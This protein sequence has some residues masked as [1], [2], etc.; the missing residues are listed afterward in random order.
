MGT[1]VYLVCS[2]IELPDDGLTQRPSL[3]ALLAENVLEDKSS[4]HPLQGVQTGIKRGHGQGA[5]V[6]AEGC[7]RKAVRP[8]CRPTAQG[9]AL[10]LCQDGGH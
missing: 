7:M 8:S 3:M 4:S 1:D 9:S 2:A 6:C 10:G 5:A